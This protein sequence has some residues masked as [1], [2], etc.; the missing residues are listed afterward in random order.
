MIGM[1]TKRQQTTTIDSGTEARAGT[2][3]HLGIELSVTPVG[4]EPII[5]GSVGRCL[6]HWAT[7]PPEQ[8]GSSVTGR[9]AGGRQIA[10]STN[11]SVG[12]SLATTGEGSPATAL[13]PVG[14]E[15]TIPGSVGPGR[16][17]TG[18]PLGRGL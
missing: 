10:H 18:W 7:G 3:E 13:T 17:F 11:D 9:I 1:M 12:R 2:E 5:P 6:I 16:C 8:V 14:L 4:L 15:P